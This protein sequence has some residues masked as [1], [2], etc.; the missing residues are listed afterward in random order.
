M[1]TVQRAFFE[2]VRA[3]LWG[4]QANAE[5]FDNNT[6]WNQLYICGKNQTLLGIM[7]DGMQTLPEELRPPRALYLK[8]CASVLQTEENNRNLNSEV[9]KLFTLLR[10]H[11]VEPVLLKGQGVARNYRQPLHRQCGDIDIFIGKQNFELVNQLL[12]TDGVEEAEPT[13]KHCSFKWHG[14]DVE[15]H[16]ILAKMNSPF[17]DRRL[18]RNIASWH[19]SGKEVQFDLAGCKVTVP[20]VEF[21]IIFILYHAIGHMLNEGVG[22]RQICDWTCLLHHN[23]A[24]IDRQAVAAELH[25]LHLERAARIFGAVA[26]KYL[27]LPAEY[28]PVG[29]DDADYE[30]GDWLLND[31]WIRGNFGRGDANRKPRPKGYWRGKWHTYTRSFRRVRDMWRVAPDEAA[32]RPIAMI[33]NLLEAQKYKYF[34]RNNKNQ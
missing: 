33:I 25:A 17:T 32:C 18:Q 13:S 2:L 4:T 23:H 3:G 34:R 12:R 16:K 5:A 10:A 27:G 30:L 1:T 11:G 8:W 21:D 15:N 31:V 6:D 26:V 22:L 24:T 29:I 19:G 28:L 20:P 7:L 14:V 9:G